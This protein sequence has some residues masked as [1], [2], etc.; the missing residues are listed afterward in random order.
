MQAVSTL[1]SVHAHEL[2]EA[3]CPRVWKLMHGTVSRDSQSPYLLSRDTTAQ[4]TG[5][6]SSAP[7]QPVKPLTIYFFKSDLEPL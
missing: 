7:A 3:F 5:F 1:L 6:G 4:G 2:Q